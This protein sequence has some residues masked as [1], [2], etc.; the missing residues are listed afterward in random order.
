MR[1]KSQGGGGLG[2]NC[3]LFEILGTF[4]T[5]I[6]ILKYVEQIPKLLIMCPDSASLLY[7]FNEIKTK[8]QKLNVECKNVV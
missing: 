3:C 6:K 1:F 7:L 2:S 4:L 8:K 5:Q